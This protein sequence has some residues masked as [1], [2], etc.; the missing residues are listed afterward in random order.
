VPTVCVT[1]AGAGV[2]SAWE[3]R[4]LEAR[5]MFVNGAESLASSAPRKS[6]GS[7]FTPE[8]VQRFCE[9]YS[10]KTEQ[11]AVHSSGGM[12]KRYPR[13]APWLPVQLIYTLAARG[14]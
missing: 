9:V 10:E 1:G 3:Q 4:K 13:G 7:F 8:T 5:K 2:D 11:Q 6:G 12:P 14:E